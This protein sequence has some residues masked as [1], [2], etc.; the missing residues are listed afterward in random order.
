MYYV[1]TSFF[2][3]LIDFELFRI[4]YMRNFKARRYMDMDKI[5]YCKYTK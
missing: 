5:E 2:V 1:E 3:R 4:H